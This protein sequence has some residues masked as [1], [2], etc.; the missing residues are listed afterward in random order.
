MSKGKFFKCF[1]ATTIAMLMTASLGFK[2]SV[3]ADTNTSAKFNQLNNNQIV[4]S[5][6]AGW[7]LGNQLEAILNQTPGETNWGNP[8][9]TKALIQEVKKAGFK[10]IRIPV[11][12]LSKIGSAP[13]YTVD[14]TWLARIK[15]VVDYA[16]SEGLY[17]I[18]NMHSDGYHTIQGAW[19]FCDSSDQTTIRDKYQKVW[20]QIASTFENYDEHVIF[21]S[22]NEEFDGNYSSPNRTYYNNINAY[23]QIFVD[24]VRQTGGNNA[25]RW[26]LIPGW[27][28]NID[29]TAGDYGFELPTDNY[30]SIDVPSSEKRIMIS[31]HYYSP[32]DFCGDESSPITQWGKDAADSSK[33]STWGQEDYLDSQFKAMY[34]KFVAQ[35]YP[36]VI[37]EYSATDKSNVDPNNNVYRAA[38]AK[39]VCTAAKKYSCVPVYWDNG[40]NGVHGCGIFDRAKCT[41]TQQEIVDAIMSVMGTSVLSGDVNNDGV[42]NG[43]DVMILTQ[44]IA[45]KNVTIDT[46]AA[47][48]NKDGTI[49][50]RDLMLLR[51]Y[52]EG[53][54]ALQ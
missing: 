22:M 37:G 46:K 3:H 25:S 26:L 2:S 50:G 39:A 11:G 51:Q 49:N 40:A 21:E 34:D 12:Y 20:K 23:N 19:L 8:V 7:N 45:G 54:V 6:G 29:Y 18:I 52:I 47:D 27:N 30:K 28:T 31:V 9:I 17:T 32:W 1:C 4:T 5:M 36:V 13:N 15:E 16:N 10:T 24:T 53:K 42:V 48:L 38:F 41:I 33:K 43:R 14:S 35:G 44:Y